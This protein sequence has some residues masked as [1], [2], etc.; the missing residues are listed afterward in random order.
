[1]SYVPP[2]FEA[3]QILDLRY[4]KI[5]DGIKLPD[6]IQIDMVYRKKYSN[7]WMY[8]VI[9][10]QA[11]GNSFMTQSKIFTNTSEHT[12]ECYKRSEI[13]KLMKLGYRF[14]ANASN[15]QDADN[16]IGILNGISEINE[17]I[18]IHAIDRDGRDIV[19]NVVG[20][21]I[22]YLTVIP[23]CGDDIGVEFKRIK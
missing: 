22:K 12:A 17:I 14:V 16:I 4:A 10:E 6:R 11:N 9:S 23:I 2:L 1:M 13:Q 20:I 8:H 7:E 21:W 5:R 3:G 15:D 19:G 18:T